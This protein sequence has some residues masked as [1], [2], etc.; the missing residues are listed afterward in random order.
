[1][2]KNEGKRNEVKPKGKKV[3]APLSFRRFLQPYL[4]SMLGEED[5]A[6]A[7]LGA[8][9]PAVNSRPIKRTNRRTSF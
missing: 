4:P 5:D 2:Q 8:E 1:M 6:A 9:E 7:G 3:G